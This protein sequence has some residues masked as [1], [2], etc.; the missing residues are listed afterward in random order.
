MSEDKKDFWQTVQDSSRQ[1]LSF[2]NRQRRKM[3]LRSQIGNHQKYIS[4]TYEKL[5]E[6]YYR[7]AADGADMTGASELMDILRSNL[8]VVDEL[9]HQLNALDGKGE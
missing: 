9:T 3:E 8:S 7:H 2:L 1:G 5:G 4:R 6:L